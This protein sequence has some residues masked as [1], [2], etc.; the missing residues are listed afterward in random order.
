MSQS[1]CGSGI[2]EWLDW[3]VLVWDLSCSYSE[4]VTG[5]A[6]IWR[7]DWGRRII[8]DG[9]LTHWQVG[10]NGWQETSVVLEPLH[11]AASVSSQQTS[12]LPLEWVNQERGKGSMKCLS[13]PSHGNCTLLS[14]KCLICWGGSALFKV[15]RDCS[16]MWITG[17]PLGAMV[18]VG[19]HS[20]TESDTE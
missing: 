18:E 6:V 9:S 3:V 12:W 13:S 19:F 20:E 8:Q 5:A 15:R 16:K 14:Q 7:F 1:S 4:E 10:A 11:R 2:W 17:S